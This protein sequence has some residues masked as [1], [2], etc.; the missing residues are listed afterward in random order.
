MKTN[1]LVIIIA[2]IVLTLNSCSVDSIRVSVNDTITYK[3]IPVSEYNTL[4]ISNN[5]K[6]FVTFSD[7]EESIKIE[8]NENLQDLVIAT[9]KN[10]KL[11]VKLKNNIHI[12]GSATLN[13]YITTKS[14]TEFKV[15]ADSKIYLENTLVEDDVNIQV[16]ADSFFSGEVDINNLELKL[17]AD[18]KADLYGSTSLLKTNLSA[19]AK[20]S[21]YDLVVEDLIIDMAA[22]CDANIT[23][24]NTIDIDATADCVLRYKG[25]ADI[26]RKHLTANSRIKKMD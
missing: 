23:V 25:N 9:I 19:D 4:E 10:N 15:A 26:I 2:I 13:V 3:D 20:L 5:F 14:I 7:T 16:T 24:T 11:T 12:N 18:A 1:R 8:T 6:A 17:S 22:D 21:D